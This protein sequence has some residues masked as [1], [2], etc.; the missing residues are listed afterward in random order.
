MPV[1]TRWNTWF[2]AALY[3]GE[4]LDHYISFVDAEI[5]HGSTQQ[6]R[7]LSTLLHGEELNVLRAELEFL[8]VHCERLIKVL[9]SLEARQFRATEIYN[10]MADL[11]AWLRNPG[12]PYATASCEDA[13]N[14]AA[15]K[16]AE[17][18]EGAKQPAIQLFQAVRIFD[19]KQLPLLS[20]TFSDYLPAIAGLSAA[21]DEWQAYMDVAARDTLPDDIVAFWQSLAQQNRLT[22]LAGLARAY[23]ALPVASVDVERLFSKYGSVLSPLRCSLAPDSIKAYCSVFYNNSSM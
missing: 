3:H 15:A 22:M 9:K 6:L 2:Q 14:N 7:K 10:Q 23:L 12:F 21:A 17:Y 19:P 18:V 16:L 11:L 4:H 13:M 1:V 20:H 5:E 8:A